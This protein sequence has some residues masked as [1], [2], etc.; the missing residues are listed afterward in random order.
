ME[1]NNI[2]IL[3]L[4]ETKSPHSKRERQEKV[5]HGTLAGMDRTNAT[6]EWD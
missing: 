6:T 1:T 2:S 5:T 3:A 4:Q